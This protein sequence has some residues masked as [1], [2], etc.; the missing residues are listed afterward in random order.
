MTYPKTS[1]IEV[2]AD[3]LKPERSDSSFL[4]TVDE[5]DRKQHWKQNLR[6]SISKLYHRHVHDS[7]R[8]GIS[9]TRLSR[10]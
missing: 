4:L 8:H 7:L 9:K 6:I 5:L 2:E 1:S 10:S 3:R